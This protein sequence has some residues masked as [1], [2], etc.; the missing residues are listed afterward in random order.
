MQIRS[1]SRQELLLAAFSTHHIMK[2]DRPSRLD[3]AISINTKRVGFCIF[4]WARLSVCVDVSCV[5]C[6]PQWAFD[7]RVGCSY[8]RVSREQKIKQEKRERQQVGWMLFGSA[9][10]FDDFSLFLA[11]TRNVCRCV[12]C[13]P[14]LNLLSIFIIKWGVHGN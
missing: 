10:R 2:I 5:L 14:R 11:A 3:A 4:P 9:Y 6:T 12:H 1:M 13:T 7:I 8:A